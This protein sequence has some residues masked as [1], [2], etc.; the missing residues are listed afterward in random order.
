MNKLKFELHTHTLHSDGGFTPRELVESAKK[1]GYYG[2]ALTDHNTTSGCDEAVEWGK[3][4][5]VLVI[6]GIEWT[7]F[8]GHVVVLGGK[9]QVDWRSITRSNVV[10]KI[11]EAQAAGD[12]VGIA[13]PY[14]VG[15]PVCTGGRNTFPF[16][17]FEHLDFYEVISGEIEDETNRRAQEEYRLINERYGISAVY[18][19]DW[20]RDIDN[21]GSKYGATYLLS[22]KENISVEEA[23]FLIKTGKTLVGTRENDI[24]LLEEQR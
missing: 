7:T 2:I 9:S 11:R 24:N 4:L 15:Y 22:D 19:R 20:H 17:I 10:D 6:P 12:V 1:Y 3:R 13:H 5:G 23:L 8:Y 18:G 14:R 21:I 16:E